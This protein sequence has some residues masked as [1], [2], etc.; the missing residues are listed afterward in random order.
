VTE[1]APRR[2]TIVYI[3]GFNL[4]FALKEKNW[5][6]FMWLDVVAL[7]RRL[8]GPD[9]DLVRVNY[10]TARI[11]RPV[12]KK[13]RQEAYLDA[14]GTLADLD[15]Y[16]GDYK[17]NSVVCHSCGRSW[18]DDKEKQTDVNIAVQMLIDAHTPN[19][20]DDLILVTA[21]SDQ[22][23]A[24]KAVRSLGKRVVIILPPGRAG[25]LEVKTAADSHFE[26][27]AKKLKKCLLPNQVTRQ[28]GFVIQKP[29][30]YT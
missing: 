23:P 30:A 26:L 29:A 12:D 5:R 2:K 22:C 8:S 14:L 11:K 28:D 15:I 25:Y 19:K 9:R 13:A 24:I 3:D 17:D 18:P 21:D 10:F 16:E 20:V 6:G 7:G 4:Y 27:T 1:N